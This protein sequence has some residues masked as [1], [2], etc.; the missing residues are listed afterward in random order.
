MTDGQFRVL[1]AI[2]DQP[3]TTGQIADVMLA[4][5]DRVHSIARRLEDKGYVRRYGGFSHWE[6]TKLGRKEMI[7]ET[8]KRMGSD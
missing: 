1:S 3:K 7:K 4:T 8:N 5:H 2:E 6:L